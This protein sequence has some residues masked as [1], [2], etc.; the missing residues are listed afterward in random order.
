MTNIRSVLEY[1]SIINKLAA[2]S[3][4]LRQVYN[5]GNLNAPVVN[6]VSPAV[7]STSRRGE[8]VEDVIKKSMRSASWT[9]LLPATSNCDSA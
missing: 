9:I 1:Q 5:R 3:R 7:A 4:P 2:S 8:I 6:P